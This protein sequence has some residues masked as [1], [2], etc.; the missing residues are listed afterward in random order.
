MKTLIWGALL[1]ALAA[2]LAMLLQHNE[3]NVVLFYP[4]YRVD[5]NLSLFAATL[6]LLFGLFYF[7]I[8]SVIVTWNMPARVANYRQRQLERK[9]NAALRESLLAFFE[10]R[11]ARTERLSATAADLPVNQDVAALLA[12]RAAQRMQE[13]ERQQNWLNHVTNKQAQ[14]ARLVTEAELH[15]DNRQPSAALAAIAQLQ[16]QGARHIHTLRLALKANQQ[17]SRWSEVI[18]LVRLLAKR[19]A[20]HVVVATEIKRRAYESLFQERQHDSEALK[21][22]W[23]DM[24]SEDR[25]D[26]FIALSAARTLVKGQL[27]GEARDI[28]E[29]ALR[30]NWQSELVLQY[31]SCAGDQPQGMIEQAE[32][33]LEVHP[34]DA[35]LQLT[36]ARLCVLIQLWGKANKHFDMAIALA[37]RKDIAK[38]IDALLPQI[39]RSAHAELAEMLESQGKLDT[40]L[41]HY[42]LAAQ[43]KP[44]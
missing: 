31:V 32:R 18:R 20:L 21:R 11:F 37:E 38:K 2:I 5:I 23:K 12:A 8:R 16:S 7:L 25:I 24:P 15:V 9:A 41:I 17:L 43:S 6:L 3:G 36:M 27:F 33:W 29:N 35:A 10:G 26:P 40:A 4:P 30:Q 39:A 44:L 14:T 13:N 28:L 34:D 22:I 42:R 1:F 19:E